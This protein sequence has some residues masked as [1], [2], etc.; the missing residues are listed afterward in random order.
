[1]EKCLI[2]SK[3]GGKMITLTKK[4]KESL[5][6]CA[7]LRNDSTVETEAE[8]E[9]ELKVHENCWKNYTNRKRISSELKKEQT[10]SKSC[11]VDTRSTSAPF[12]CENECFI[13]GEYF[14]QKH[15]A[16][17]LYRPVLMLKIRT[18]LLGDCE[19][20]L[21][22]N[23]EDEK[24][25]AVR[26]R[27]LD[28]IDLVAV[29]AKYHQQCRVEFSLPRKVENTLSGAPTNIE[30]QELFERTCE[31]LESKPEVHT[32]SDFSM[33]MME[34][35]NSNQ[36]YSNKHIKRCLEEKY[37]SCV[38]I[39]YPGHGKPDII[40][41]ETESNTIENER[42][43]IKVGN[44]IKHEINELEQSMFYPTSEQLSDLDYL[45]SLLPKNLVSLLNILIP[46]T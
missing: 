24:A 8:K 29:N 33:K 5:I 12:N 36:S 3:S 41:L 26:A 39:V 2:C 45:Q 9:C 14:N 19:N 32:V 38:K 10:E 35:S 27:L 31:W 22:L 46:N 15:K 16:W 20:R 13:F 25:K 40:E 28:C 21:S 11:K 17:K 1:M 4:G 7:H 18:T 34:L 30:L 6:Q 42:M 37:G 43:I 23:S 44:L